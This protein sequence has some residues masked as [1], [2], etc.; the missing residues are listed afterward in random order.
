MHV[1]GES[2]GIPEKI[3]EEMET[4]RCEREEIAQRGDREASPIPVWREFELAKASL[5]RKQPDEVRE[6]WKQV[7]LKGPIPEQ[8]LSE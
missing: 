1:W 3:R 4:M 5:W 2:D 6:H 8:E 7:S